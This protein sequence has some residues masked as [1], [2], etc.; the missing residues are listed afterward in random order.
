MIYLHQYFSALYWCVCVS[1]ANLV[2]QKL[3]HTAVVPDVPQEHL[4]CL[5]ANFICINT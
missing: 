1:L 3:V 5:D 4:S 2:L